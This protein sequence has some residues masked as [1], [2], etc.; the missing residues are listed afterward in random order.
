MRDLSRFS[1]RH[2]LWKCSA[3]IL[4]SLNRHSMANPAAG[5]DET[6]WLQEFSGLRA[7]IYM[8]NPDKSNCLTHTIMFRD[9]DV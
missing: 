6:S 8:R 7:G 1:D 3:Q 4:I 9:G 2:K 5:R